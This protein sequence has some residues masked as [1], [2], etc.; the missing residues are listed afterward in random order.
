MA[1][2][3]TTGR[4]RTRADRRRVRGGNTLSEDEIAEIERKERLAKLPRS[5]RPH[6]GTANR[7]RIAAQQMYAAME[8]YADEMNCERGELSKESKRRSMIDALAF[9]AGNGKLKELTALV[10]AAKKKTED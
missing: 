6:Y 7:L 5:Q 10:A 4:T 3:R 9:Y 1:L 8:L 2:R